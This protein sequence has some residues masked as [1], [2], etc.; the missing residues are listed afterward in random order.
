MNTE[1]IGKNEAA[2]RL[3]MAPRSV[4]ALASAQKI[5]TKRD[6]D[7]KTQQVATMFSAADVERYG[8]ER[9]HPEE[10]PAVSNGAVQT[11][12]A[13][14]RTMQA[15]QVVMPPK[16][17]HSPAWMTVD[18]AATYTALPPS[19]LRHLIRLG[20]LMVLKVGP[21][22]GGQYRLSKKD[23]DAIQGRKYLGG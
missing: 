22:T 19:F 16:P 2:A 23:L 12:S 1:W 18:E 9:D 17:A 11:V 21:R 5:I 14:P 10:K 7:P 3:K 8:Y 6:R 13:V 20:E 15:L 4:L